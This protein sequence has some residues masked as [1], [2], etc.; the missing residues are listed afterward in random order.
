MLLRKDIVP[1]QICQ[2]VF[3]CE[4]LLW[5]Y[6]LLKTVWWNTW[7]NFRESICSNLAVLVYKI[8]RIKWITLSSLRL[9]NLKS[10]TIPFVGGKNRSS[11]TTKLPYWKKQTERQKNT[12]WPNSFVTFLYRMRFS[13]IL[14]F[15][16][17]KTLTEVALKEGGMDYGFGLP[18]WYLWQVLI[19][20][21][22]FQK[23]TKG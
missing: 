18:Y 6:L 3:L 17:L 16:V 2:I 13:P 8:L 7:S 20:F 12:L 11:G 15:L 1:G 19:Q 23:E 9:S 5:K 22:C 4:I 10:F 21:Q 14:V